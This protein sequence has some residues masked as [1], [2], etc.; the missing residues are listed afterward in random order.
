MRYFIEITTEH[1]NI[2]ILIYENNP[3]IGRKA[4]GAKL[5]RSDTVPLEEQHYRLDEIVDLIRSPHADHLYQRT[6]E[7]LDE[8]D[9]V[10]IGHFLY[11]QLFGDIHPAKLQPD[12]NEAVD[13]RIITDD[14]FIAS[15]PWPLLAHQ[16]SF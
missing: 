12:T 9:Q 3:T 2:S 5:R 7:N 10:D 16:A 14:E 6:Q 11:Q 15:L 1:D 13:L 8:R 4:D